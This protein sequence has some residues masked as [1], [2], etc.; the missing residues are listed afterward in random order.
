MHYYSDPIMSWIKDNLKD[1][2]I[3]NEIDIL[4]N[5]I[6]EYYPTF[7]LILTALNIL[8]VM[9]YFIYLFSLVTIIDF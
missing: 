3:S 1:Y 4:N 5:R 9:L 6:T 7:N 8:I 2:E